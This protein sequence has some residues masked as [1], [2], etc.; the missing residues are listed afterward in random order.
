VATDLIFLHFGH[1]L[2]CSA[3]VDK[4]FD[5]YSTLQYMRRGGVELSYDRQAFLLEGE[6]F[7]PAYPGPLIWFHVA[8]GYPWWE[9]R[10]A[11]FRGPLLNRWVA[12]G[13]FP[14]RP[15][16]APRPRFYAKRFDELLRQLE[17]PDRWGTLRAV[18]LL[19]R[20]LIDLA[21]ARAQ[22]GEREPWLVQV[23]E[24]LAAGQNTDYAL[25]ASEAG[26]A[27]STLRRRFRQAVGTSLHAY[28]LQCKIARARGMLSET[29]RPM[30]A[31]AEELGY[32]DIYFFSRQFHQLTGVPPAAYRKS[33]Q[34]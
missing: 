21:E 28:A 27:L 26:M 14:M 19:E 32:Q 1:T 6:W 3:V 24:T 2:Q 8:P 7:W 15:Q 20:L 18:N 29:D 4:C 30:K 16:P 31:I 13:L 33:R 12:E 25:L 17:R 23:M 22:P 5:G 34:R 10:Y 11:A 9:H